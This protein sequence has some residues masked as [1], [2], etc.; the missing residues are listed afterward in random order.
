M[1]N[2]ISLTEENDFSFLSKTKKICKRAS[3]VYE[4]L[5]DQLINEFGVNEDFL[6]ILKN[7]IK[8]ELYYCSQ[9][10][11]GDK[12]NQIFIDILEI[13]NNDLISKQ[14]KTDLYESIIAIEKIMGFKVD[15]KK[16][17][18]FDFYKYSRT[19]SNKMKHEKDGGKR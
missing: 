12:S 9:I 19:I 14:T 15:V 8:I 5:H 11:T 6:R 17:S 10:E 1:Y 18:V 13:Q 7:K 16:I 3:K 4:K 2:W